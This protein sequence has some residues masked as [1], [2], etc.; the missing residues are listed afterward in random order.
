MRA[1]MKR[2]ALIFFVVACGLPPVPEKPMG[3]PVAPSQAALTGVVS[4]A[5]GP[6]DGPALEF[7]ID[8]SASCLPIDGPAH[9]LTVNLWIDVPYVGEYKVGGADRFGFGSGCVGTELCS[10]SQSGTFTIDSFDLATNQ[11]AGHYD[12]QLESGEKLQRNFR[13][14]F[15]AQSQRFCG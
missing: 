7:V 4:R 6:A 1:D 8:P 9:Q 2:L 11:I 12:I 13:V 10:A 3:T 15:C 5:C 14:S